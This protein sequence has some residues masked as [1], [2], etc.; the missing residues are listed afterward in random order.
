LTLDPGEKQK[1]KEKEGNSWETDLK[2]YMVSSFDTWV[3]LIDLP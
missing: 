1:K 3:D 2:G